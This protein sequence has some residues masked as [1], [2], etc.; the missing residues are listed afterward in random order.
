MADR[1]IAI[2]VEDLLYLCD[3]VWLEIELGEF[4]V[5]LSWGKD[6]IAIGI[7]QLEDFLD[8]FALRKGVNESFDSREVRKVI[9]DFLLF[10]VLIFRL[11]FV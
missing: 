11:S 3:D 1:A 4:I 7:D 6:S 5:D 10:F 8:W 2:F 9:M